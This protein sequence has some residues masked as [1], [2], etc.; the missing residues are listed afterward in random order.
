MSTESLGWVKRLTGATTAAVRV[1]TGPEAP[2]AGI[3]DLALRKE[4]VPNLD[5]ARL[6][7]YRTEWAAAITAAGKASLVIVLDAELDETEARTVSGAGA[8][9][10]IG[11]VDDDRFP[12]AALV[13]PTTNMAEENGTYVNRNGR[14]QRYYQAKAVPGM[15]RP[16]WWIAAEAIEPGPGNVPTTAAEAFAEL[17]TFA[18]ALAGLTYADLGHTGRVL[19]SSPPAGAAR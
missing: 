14:V 3:P 5:G 13:L 11:T 2:L 4:R 12:G 6:L 17:G 19:E 16:A 1:P 15:A 8:V 9:V 10:V 18:P 7:G